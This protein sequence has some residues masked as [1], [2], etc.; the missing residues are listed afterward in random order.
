MIIFLAS[1]SMPSSP[2]VRNSAVFFAEDE[3]DSN[4]KDEGLFNNSSYFTSIKCRELDG[5]KV[6]KYPNLSQLNPESI[7]DGTVGLVDESQNIVL[8]GSYESF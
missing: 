2:V 4:T 7:P 5:L 8:P 1:M 3:E 6:W